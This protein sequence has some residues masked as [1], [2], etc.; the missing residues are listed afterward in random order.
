MVRVGWGLVQQI[1]L[2][3]KGIV[4]DC[5]RVCS[6]GLITLFRIRPYF[7]VLQSRDLHLKVCFPLAKGWPW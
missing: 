7:M 4:A 5:I 2:N 1:F 6:L 3:T